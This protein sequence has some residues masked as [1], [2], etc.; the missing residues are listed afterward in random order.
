MEGSSD[1]VSKTTHVD[2]IARRPLRAGWPLRAGGGNFLCDGNEN[3]GAEIPAENLSAGS[4]AF[5]NWSTSAIGWSGSWERGIDPAVAAD[6]GQGAGQKQE[7]RS[8][9]ARRQSVSE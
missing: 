4:S 7:H 6:A 2:G 8:G 3:S 1:G 9:D 5:V